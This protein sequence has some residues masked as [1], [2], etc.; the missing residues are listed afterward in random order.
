M[1]GT[2]EISA[3]HVATVDVPFDC[4]VT[5]K[6]AKPGETVQIRLWQTAGTHP[7]FDRSASA[8]IRADGTGTAHFETVTLAGPCRAHMFADDTASTVPLAEDDHYIEVVP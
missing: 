1:A 6:G 7:L 4:R 8:V 5:I 3:L 2:L